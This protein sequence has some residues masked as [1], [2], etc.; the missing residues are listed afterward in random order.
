MANSKGIPF[1]IYTAYGNVIA[2]MEDYLTVGNFSFKKKPVGEDMNLFI[3]YSMS[4]SEQ[5]EM[6]RRI[7]GIIDFLEER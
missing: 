7:A 5:E 2:I 3:I 1:V 6:V 4:E